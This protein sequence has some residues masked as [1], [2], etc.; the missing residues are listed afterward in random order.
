MPR[1]IIVV[2]NGSTRDD[3]LT[4][5]RALELQGTIKA[6][7]NRENLGPGAAR[8][9]AMELAKGEYLLCLDSDTEVTP[10][11]VERLVA[12]M[13]A[14]SEV[15]L[16][17]A[18]LHAPGGT[19]QFT[20]GRFPTLQSKLYRQLPGSLRHRA[21][22]EH[23]FRNWDHR[24]PR[25]VDTAISACHMIRRVALDAVGGYD[26]K[27][28]YAPEDV[29][30]CLRMWQAG[31]KVLYEGRAVVIHHEQRIT[32][33]WTKLLSRATREHLRGLVY[34]FRKHRYLFRPPEFGLAEP[35]L[36]PEELVSCA[37][38]SHA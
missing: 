7:F 2:D 16:C 30:L 31:W 33:R 1:E 12:S 35:E 22:R 10:G 15:G 11:A 17:A 3:S 34:Y 18:R 26:P 19:L 38:E 5:L 21:L 20:C 8:N 28:F 4:L 32:K 36:A 29:D 25:F 37:E 27:I 23:E 13:D 14:H 6:I 24:S 9:Q